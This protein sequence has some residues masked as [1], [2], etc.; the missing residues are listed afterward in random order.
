MAAP[1]RHRG[2]TGYGPLDMAGPGGCLPAGPVPLLPGL[3][4]RRAS[5]GA[6]LHQA[7]L[8]CRAALST[9]PRDGRAAA[10]GVRFWFR[11]SSGGEMVWLAHVARI[12]RTPQI[13]RSGLFHSA[14]HGAAYSRRRMTGHRVAASAAQPAWLPARPRAD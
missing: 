10:P 11:Y 12:A 2:R 9:P 6:A 13:E 8:V 4:R 1:G 3:V 14:R 7:V 5:P